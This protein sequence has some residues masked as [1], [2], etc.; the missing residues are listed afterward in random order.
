MKIKISE[1]KKLVRAILSEAEADT[2]PAAASAA[3][4]QFK[5]DTKGSLWTAP[6]NMKNNPVKQKANQVLSVLAKRN[7]ALDDQE[8]QRLFSMLSELDPTDLLLKS[9]DELAKEYE[10]RI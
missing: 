1:V 10:K 7:V 5:D 9:A 3:E 8:K 6:Q 4:K 2:I